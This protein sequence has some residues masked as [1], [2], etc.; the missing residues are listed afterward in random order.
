[1]TAT[2]TKRNGN[3]LTIEL[4]IEL[5]GSMLDMENQI[6]DDLNQAGRLATAEALK[7]F[8]TDGSPI[9]ISKTKLTARKEKASQHYESPYGTVRVDRYLYQSNEGGYAKQ[10]GKITV[11]TSGKQ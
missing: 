11:T 10:F 5:G 7:E 1:M 6:Q 9:I 4:T 2:V 8:D 3:V